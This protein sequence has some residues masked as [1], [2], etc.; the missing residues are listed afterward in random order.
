MS[1]LAIIKHKKKTLDKT[2]KKYLKIVLALIIYNFACALINGL[3]YTKPVNFVINHLGVLKGFQFHRMFLS[4]AVTWAIIFAASLYLLIQWGLYEKITASLSK[5]KK[6]AQ[7]AL[8]VILCMAMSFSTL[9]VYE[10]I[11]P[12]IGY[13]ETVGRIFNK[14][15]IKENFPT[16]KQYVD[17]ALFDSI[18]TY[19]GRDVK[20]YKVVSLG[21][22][23]AI[24]SMN[25]FYTLDGFFQNY[26]LEYKHEFR[27]IIATELD[28]SQHL[29]EYYDYWGNKCYIMSSE[30][31]KEYKISKNAG[32]EINNLEIDTKKLKEMGGDYIFSALPINNYQELNLSLDG[33]FERDNSYW[34][35]YLYKV[36]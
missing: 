19:I 34:K 24:I 29:K 26:P 7:V 11:S 33:I 17:K 5:I 1:I 22:Y 3:Y 28:K 9:G 31:I 13:Y 23:P 25:G 27:E 14:D 20:D 35:I 18:E 4:Y 12:D 10:I 16:Y 21:I 2:D 8:G 15:E 30:I 36:S 32:K 6:P